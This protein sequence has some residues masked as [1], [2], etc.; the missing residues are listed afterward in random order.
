MLTIGDGLV[1]VIPAL[2]ISVSRRPDRHA[3]QFRLA[4]WARI[5]S[6]QIFGKSQPLLLAGGVLIA[7]A[8]FPG[9]PKIPFL[10]LGAG[11]GFGG[12]KMRRSEAGQEEARTAAASGQSSRQ[13]R[14]A[15]ESG[16]AG[17]RSGSGLVEPGGRRPELAAA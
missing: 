17:D 1:T 8:A 12:W 9:L 10:L 16:A 14:N 7:M 5:S 15:A 11:A 13:Y 2:M 4:G 3:R 6:K